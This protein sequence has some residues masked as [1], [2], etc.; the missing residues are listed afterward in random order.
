MGGK[1]PGKKETPCTSI[2]AIALRPTGGSAGRPMK[3]MRPSLL[4]LLQGT[5]QTLGRG[6][7][8][9][10]DPAPPGLREALPSPGGL[11]SKAR[12]G[13]GKVTAAWSQQPSSPQW[14]PN[15]AMMPICT[16]PA[17]LC[18]SPAARGSSDPAE[19][20]R[21][22]AG[23]C[24]LGRDIHALP[25]PSLARRAPVLTAGLEYRALNQLHACLWCQTHIPRQIRKDRSNRASK[26][27]SGIFFGLSSAPKTWCYLSFLLK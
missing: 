15:P 26:N 4:F 19:G 21:V 1:A 12:C 10:A 2:P 20:C 7:T 24:P 13:L 27:I 3:R 22:A 25:A 16:V 23:S 18:R 14:L 9:A 8:A 11:Q 17:A 5:D 6:D